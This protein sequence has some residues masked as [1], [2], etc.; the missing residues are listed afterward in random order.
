MTAQ[1][2]NCPGNEMSMILDHL[3]GIPVTLKFQTQTFFIFCSKYMR[4]QGTA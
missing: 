1:M 3:Y 4:L 2:R